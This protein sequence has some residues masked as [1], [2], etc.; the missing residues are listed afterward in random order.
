MPP[1]QGQLSQD[2]QA[3]GTLC[4]RETPS[5]ARV[6]AEA[7]GCHRTLCHEENCNPWAMLPGRR[8]FLLLSMHSASHALQDPGALLAECPGSRDGGLRG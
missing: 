5:R 8:N 4:R 6:L 3:R 2:S 7:R 1:P